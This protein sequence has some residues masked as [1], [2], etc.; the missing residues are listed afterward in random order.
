MRFLVLTLLLVI[1]LG[2]FSQSYESYRTGNPE[3]LDVTPTFGVCLMGGGA[4]NDNA[5]QWFLNLANGGDVLVLRTSGSDAYNPYFYNQLGVTLNSV[6]TLV[7]TS[8][9]ASQEDY[10]INRINQAEAIWFAG[11]DQSDY[12]NFFKSNAINVALNHH[13]NIKQAAIGGTSAGMAILSDYYFSATNG[14]VTSFEALFNPFHPNISLGES[15]F[16]NVP[17]LE[18][19]ITDTHFDNPDRKGRLSVFIARLLM[20]NP[21]TSVKGIAAEE[22][23]AICIDQN[24][25][26]K[27]YGDYPEFEDYAYFVQTNCELSPAETIEQNEPITWSINQSA[28]DVIK[29]P[30][31]PTGTYQFDLNDWQTS[32]WSTWEHWYINNGNFNSSASLPRDCTQ[33]L[34]DTS[35]VNQVKAYPNPFSEFVHVNLPVRHKI[36]SVYNAYGQAVDFIFKS[37]QLRLKS[38][39]KG[40]YYVCVESNSGEISYL[41]LIKH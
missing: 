28:I 13:I 35:T 3:S 16:L 2:C 19:T 8:S 21:N 25:M 27:V 41:S 1:S 14:T 32:N 10:V 7:I 6:E 4:E 9:Q 30:A 31:T 23:T 22:F 5:M 11:G 33:L 24:A 29:I 39:S 18:E 34:V 20:T 37:K 36:K 40:V 26:A 38:Q 12:I 15:D 17:L